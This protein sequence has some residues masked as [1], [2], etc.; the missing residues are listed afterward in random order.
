MTVNYDEAFPLPEPDFLW[1]HDLTYTPQ[2]A[3]SV[4]EDTSSGKWRYATAPSVVVEFTGYITSAGRRDIERAKA[5]G[6][7]ADAVALISHDVPG[8]DPLTAEHAVIGC[9]STSGASPWLWGD[10]T[11]GEVRPNPSHIR[12]ILTRIVGEKPANAP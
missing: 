6:I 3:A 9:G 4:V 2:T 11:V 12:A 7:T 5:R 10:Y 1:I 8:I